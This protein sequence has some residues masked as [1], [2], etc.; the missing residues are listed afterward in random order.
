MLLGVGQFSREDAGVR[1]FPSR[2]TLHPTGEPTGSDSP[3]PRRPAT[4]AGLPRRPRG[5]TREGKLPC[6]RCFSL[7]RGTISAIFKSCLH[8]LH[9]R[10]APD[11]RP[12]PR[13]RATSSPSISPPIPMEGAGPEPGDRA[14]ERMRASRTSR[15]QRSSPAPRY[16]S[17]CASARA[18]APCAPPKPT[19]SSPAPCS[20]PAPALAS[21]SLSRPGPRHAPRGPQG[22]G[23][24]ASEPAAPRSPGRSPLSEA[25][26]RPLL[27]RRPVRRLARACAALG[28]SRRGPGAPDGG[29]PAH[30]ASARGVAAPRAHRPVGGSRAGHETLIPLLKAC[31][32]GKHAR[33]ASIQDRIR[34]PC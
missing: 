6:R 4:R 10:D 34:R 25:L 27:L 28:A 24:C 12:R 15:G 26:G 30:L 21:G 9:V 1:P 18:L 17:P 19:G 11:R 32:Y 33:T 31:C 3:P 22:A 8:A 13:A 29:A 20:S 5:K 16:T 23:L 2:P 14:R 7:T